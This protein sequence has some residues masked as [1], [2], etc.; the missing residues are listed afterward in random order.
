MGLIRV[1]IDG[2]E[3]E[4]LEGEYLL[5]V[6]L[7][8]GIYIPNLCAIREKKEPYGGCRLC[9]VEIEGQE[10]PSTACTL[11]VKEG[12]RI[13]TKGPKAL[14]L[15]RTA[16]ELILS[17]HPVDCGHCLKTGLCELQKIAK[18]LGIKL[19]TQRLTKFLRGLPIDETSPVFVY[20]PNKCVLCGRCVWYCHEKIGIG[21]IGFAYRGFQR[22]VTTF[23]N[24]PVGQSECRDRKELV[25][26]C[27]VG[28]FGAK[29]RRMGKQ[30]IHQ[31]G[32]ST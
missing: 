6:A 4:C 8:H 1:S 15:A 23:D 16:F 20:D 22:W 32:G 31:I 2:Q 11:R 28:A 29:E 24:A 27:P 30:K 25:E 12:M 5:W 21:E 14:R 17:N 19:S 10:A 3:M 18:H 9:F 26:I 13:Q 7:D